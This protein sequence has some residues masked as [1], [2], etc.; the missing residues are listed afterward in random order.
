MSEQQS[1]WRNWLVIIGALVITAVLAG[2]WPAI[3]SNFAPGGPTTS[4]PAMGIP[5]LEVPIP[6]NLIPTLDGIIPIT[7]GIWTLNGLIAILGLTAIIIGGTAL[8]GAG[9]AFAVRFID[10]LTAQEKESETYQQKQ[11]ELEKVEKEQIKALREGRDPTPRPEHK[12]PRWSR[13]ANILIFWLF[14]IFAGM[15][16]NRTFYPTGEI[17]LQPGDTLY[18][19]LTRLGQS[20]ILDTSWLFIWLP[21][22]LLLPLAIWWLR[23]QR[24]E[25][26]DAT[27]YSNIPW[28]FLAVMLTGLLVVGLGLAYMVYFAVPG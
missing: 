25:A 17:L 26:T 24:I 1:S 15:I 27:D 6:A 5:M 2:A 8:I 18:S 21:T 23:P 7:D 12:M 22:L 28:D 19:L 4:T 16:A 3:T 13:L 9:L 10:N 20:P 11:A 14:L